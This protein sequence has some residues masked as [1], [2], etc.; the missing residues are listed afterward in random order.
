MNTARGNGDNGGRTGFKTARD[1]RQEEEASGY[2]DPDRV[3]DVASLEH[4]GPARFMSD[5]TRSETASASSIWTR[6]ET[7]SIESGWGLRPGSPRLRMPRRGDYG[8][9]D[10]GGRDRD[11]EIREAGKPELEELDLPSEASDPE[12]KERVESWVSQNNTPA[13]LPQQRLGARYLDEFPSPRHDG[14][15]RALRSPHGPAQASHDD[16]TPDR[17]ANA[18]PRDWEADSVVVL[19]QAP[20]RSWEASPRLGAATPRSA[21]PAQQRQPNQFTPRLGSPRLGLPSAAFDAAAGNKGVPMSSLVRGGSSMY[22]AATGTPRPSSSQDIVLQRRGDTS[23][24]P[25][26]IVQPNL[27]GHRGSAAGLDVVLPRVQLAKT[28]LWRSP[29]SPAIAPVFSSMPP[30]AWVPEKRG[31]GVFMP[32]MRPEEPDSGRFMV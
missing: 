20:L 17:S 4:D 2:N 13:N 1:P 14:H 24:T 26:K 5:I 11:W 8:P 28:S 6:E 27:S 3:S 31:V 29:Q 9:K 23:A 16:P 10:R 25:T 32:E 19:K 12:L 22:G 7:Q 30:Q 18:G 21:D 15:W